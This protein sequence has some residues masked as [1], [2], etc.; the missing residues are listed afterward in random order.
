MLFIR[1][2]QDMIVWFQK[3]LES[4]EMSITAPLFEGETYEIEVYGK[5]GNYA[6]WCGG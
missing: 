2:S 1:I 4:G 6:N 5:G 3:W